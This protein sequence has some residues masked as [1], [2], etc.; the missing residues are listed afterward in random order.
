MPG[1][2]LGSIPG[3]TV[4][5]D[6]NTFAVGIG[7]VDGATWYVDM[8]GLEAGIDNGNLEAVGVI[9]CSR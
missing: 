4:H 9:A 1:P 7:S 2:V 8:C 6:A 3:L 5:S